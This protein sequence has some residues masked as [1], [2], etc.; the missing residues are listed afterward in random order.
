MKAIATKQPTN[1]SVKQNKS[2]EKGRSRS[3]SPLST[4]MP[5]LQRK[6]AC[7]G[8][9]PRC[10]EELGIQTKLKIG[11]PGDK[12][13]QEADRVADEVMR[14]PESD[15]Q[16]QTK[17]ETGMIQL[18]SLNPDTFTANSQVSNVPP[19]VDEVLN[20]PGQPLNLETRAFM[21]PRF[22]QDFSQVRIHTDAKAVESASAINARAYTVGKDIV[23]GSGEYSPVSFK[24]LK[25][26]AHELTHGVQQHLASNL[27][28]PIALLQRQDDELDENIN[29]DSAEEI[30]GAE[31]MSGQTLY[32]QTELSSAEELGKKN[33]TCGGVVG[34]KVA[35]FDHDTVLF[36]T[37]D[38][39]TN[40]TVKLTA[41]MAAGSCV[42]T[43]NNYEI[44]IEN[45]PGT[46]KRMP[47]GNRGIEGECDPIPPQPGNV[48]FPNITAGKHKLIIRNTIANNFRLIVKGSITVS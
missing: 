24:G 40:V 12:Y 48:R 9:C 20:S 41:T 15:I 19:I 45:F 13:E 18:K 22:G 8:G 2:G 10:K 32:G 44:E 21:E 5:L 26:L 35:P 28:T 37:S 47:A 34:V 46:K 42:N 23:F 16:R 30:Q 6:C 17:P 36:F 27:Q 39:C 25:L 7:G 31:E 11:K 29:A 3:I 43:K 14:I 38:N 33:T 4:G 1:A